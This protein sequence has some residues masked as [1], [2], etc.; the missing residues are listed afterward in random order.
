[1]ISNTDYRSIADRLL[2]ALEDDIR[3][4]LSQ[5][6]A[7]NEDR[8]DISKAIADLNLQIEAVKKGRSLVAP[9]IGSSGTH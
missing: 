8:N 3:L 1:M 6:D 2:E 9:V 7:E 4:K 5:W